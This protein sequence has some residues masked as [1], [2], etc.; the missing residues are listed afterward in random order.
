MKKIKSHQFYFPLALALSLSPMVFKTIHK[1]VKPHMAR[2][3]ASLNETVKY[4]KEVFEKDSALIVESLSK[5]EKQ[6]LDVVLK[7]DKAF[8]QSLHDIVNDQF[9]KIDELEKLQTTSDEDKKIV[10]GKVAELRSLAN[11]LCDRLEKVA[12]STKYEDKKEEKVSV[13]GSEK[14]EDCDLQEKYSELTKQVEAMTADHKKYLDVIVGMNQMMISM[15]QQ[16]QP[17]Y[18]PYT[19][20]YGPFG[21]AYYPYNNANGLGQVTNNYYYGSSG[22]QSPMIMGFGQNLPSAPAQ[23]VGGQPQQISQPMEQ[24]PAMPQ[25]IQGIDPRFGMMNMIPGPFGDAPFMHNFG[26]ADASQMPGGMIVDTGRA[27]AV[28]PFF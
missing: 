9:A 17:Q 12:A 5:V 1:E 27:P 13:E 16:H 11:D 28:T 26:G 7:K 23:M 18:S 2:S 24:I 4:E 19:Y 15:Y 10:T 3:I 6:L 14:K 21:Q 8:E 20:S 22:T 25:T